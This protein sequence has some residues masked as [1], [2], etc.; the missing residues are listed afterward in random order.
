MPARLS[1]PGV[2]GPATDAP[3]ADSAYCLG[4]VCERDGDLRQAAQWFRE[5]AE[6]GHTAARLRLGDVLGRLAD[7]EWNGTGIADS[8]KLLAE[9]SRWL[10]GAPATATPG[11]IGLITD[12]LNR[13]QRAAARRGTPPA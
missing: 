10:S 11:G 4:V 5:A 6:A 12:M 1:S 9:A 3:F 13:H 2:L 8:E 7:Q